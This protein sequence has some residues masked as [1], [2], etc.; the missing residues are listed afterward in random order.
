MAKPC[1]PTTLIP[2][3]R[4]KQQWRADSLRRSAIPQ[5]HQHAPEWSVRYRLP[6]GSGTGAACMTTDP[7]H[8]PHLSRPSAGFRLL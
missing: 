7:R 3:C 8:H 2:F 6:V 1:L 5:I 4:P